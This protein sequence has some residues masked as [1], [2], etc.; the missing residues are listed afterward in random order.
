LTTYFFR[1]FLS[2]TFLPGI[3]S[4]VP[5]S[6]AIRAAMLTTSHGDGRRSENALRI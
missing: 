3:A 2:V 1:S 5:A 6:A 4:A